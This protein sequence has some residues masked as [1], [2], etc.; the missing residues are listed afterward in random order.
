MRHPVPQVLLDYNSWREKGPPHLCHNCLFYDEHGICVKYKMTP[1][2]E[3]AATPSACD[4][5]DIECPF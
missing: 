1:P 3:F 5:W 4:Q 2:E